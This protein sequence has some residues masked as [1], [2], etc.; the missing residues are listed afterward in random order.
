VELFRQAPKAIDLVLMDLTMPKMGGWDAYVAMK[1]IDPDVRVVFNSG[2][3]T[4]EKIFEE[5]RK[6]GRDLILKPFNRLTLL[7]TIHR[8]LNQKPVAG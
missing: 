6:S 7:Q 5:I 4:D 8:V 3:A 1:D 2:H